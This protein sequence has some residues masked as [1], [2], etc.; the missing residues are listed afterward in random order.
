M[1]NIK[2]FVNYYM[3][4]HEVVIFLMNI[5]IY[6]VLSKTRLDRFKRKKKISFRNEPV[7]CNHSSYCVICNHGSYGAGPGNSGD[8][9][10]S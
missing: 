7:I 10:F 4:R 6:Y 2:Q 1:V 9:I 5:N 3:V 8:F